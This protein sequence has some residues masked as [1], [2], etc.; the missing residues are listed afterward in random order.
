MTLYC[1]SK[2]I[3]ANSNLQQNN[4]PIQSI[5]HF[6][7]PSCWFLPGNVSFSFLFSL[8]SSRLA[9]FVLRIPSSSSNFLTVVDLPFFHIH[10]CSLIP[11]S[12][13]YISVLPLNAVSAFSF[14]LTVDS[15]PSLF[16][17]LFS[18]PTQTPSSIATFSF[19]TF[20]L[21][22]SPSYTR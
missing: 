2:D 4:H 7:E 3:K 10:H 5:N 11:S 22:T 20:L 6:P 8:S 15:D 21:F 16:L 19:P 18:L 14:L 17:S 9:H 12:T 1:V 13:F